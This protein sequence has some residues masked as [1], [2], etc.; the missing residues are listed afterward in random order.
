[1]ASRGRASSRRSLILR[2]VLWVP[3][4]V[5]VVVVAARY[6]ANR[7]TG[8]AAV[9]AILLGTAPFT[10]KLREWWNNPSP[11][12]STEE[13]ISEAA[14]ELRKLVYGKWRPSA[15]FAKMGRLEDSMGIFWQ[16]AGTDTT[17]PISD[18]ITTYCADPRPLIVLGKPGAGKTALSILLLLELISKSEAEGARIP[19]LV[20]LS[21]WKSEIGYDAWLTGAIYEQYDIYRTL[22]DTSKFG[23]DVVA[24]LRENG[25]LLPILD[26]LDELPPDARTTVIEQIRYS[27]AFDSPFIL[28]SRTDE[29]VTALDN[30][31]ATRKETLR[32]LPMM[33]EA[34]ADYL[35]N[36]FS[37]DVE[38]WRPVIDEITLHPDGAVAATLRKPLMLYLALAH[39]YSS[40]TDPSALLDRVAHPDGEEIEQ[41]LLGSFVDTA[42]S[43]RSPA[44]PSPGE[45]TPRPPWLLGPDRA[46]SAL[47]F[48]ARYLEGL[49]ASSASHGVEDLNWWNLYQYV[50]RYLVVLTPVLI[51]ALG[52]GLLGRVS[53]G[54]FGRPGAGTIFGLAV[55]FVGGLA[56]GIIRP[57]P[58][59]Q[60]VPRSLWQKAGSRQLLVM[61]AILG[62]IGAVSGSVISSVIISPVYGLTN[63]LVFGL[64]FA[65][66]RRFTRPTEPKRGVS[67]L[68]A[69]RAD[70][71][72]VLW[73]FLAGALVGAGV[74]LVDG[75]VSAKFAANLIYKVST[76][77]R[78]LIGA[79]VGMVLG[80]AGLGMVMMATSAWS[81]FLAAR[82]WLALSGKTPLRLMRFLEDACEL[83]VLRRVG[84]SYQFRH[85][86]LQE[87]LAH[88][89]AARRSKVE[90]EV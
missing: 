89:D 53:F 40:T 69:L 24:R 55:G 51:G 45:Q 68:D 75:L 63:G 3:L 13:Q 23:L 36:H 33:P 56:L 47:S 34:V 39:F 80:G 86:L 5:V 27:T 35:R 72:A 66:M 58:P 74:G 64:A 11:E 31:S 61:D 82:T 62:L 7:I 54:L 8:Y 48:L 28:T 32:L 20:R 67:P 85:A 41:Y 37:G 81:H 43:P 60:F 57:K 78:G 30:K 38:R 50:P 83:G 52:C 12:Q 90:L 19:V 44:P 84:A 87:Q 17:G 49:H 2:C 14:V 73:A 46:R 26:G 76:P 79:G 22:S 59:V 4:A 15:E 29:Y 25:S 18:L 71:D 70:R 9:G 42:F 77:E 21:S 65:L 10:R 6:G 16:D 1:M 88:G